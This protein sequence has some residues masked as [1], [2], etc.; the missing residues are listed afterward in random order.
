M[1]MTPYSPVMFSQVINQSMRGA[2]TGPTWKM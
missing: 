1:H 2:R